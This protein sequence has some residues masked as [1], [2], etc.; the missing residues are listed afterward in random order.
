MKISKWPM[1]AVREKGRRTRDVAGAQH[2]RLVGWEKKQKSKSLPTMTSV[3]H[4]GPTNL[5]LWEWVRGACARMDVAALSACATDVTTW[6]CRSAFPVQPCTPKSNTAL[7]AT[8][9]LDHFRKSAAE[10]T[11]KVRMVVNISRGSLSGEGLSG[12]WLGG[13]CTTDVRFFW[14]ALQIER[15]GDIEEGLKAI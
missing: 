6:R 11:V 3:V 14:G 2:F 10:G 7:F 12:K 1:I 15:R 8:R 5:R 9:I 4:L 13:G